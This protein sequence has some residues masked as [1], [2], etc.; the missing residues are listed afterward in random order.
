MAQKTPTHEVVGSNPVV[1]T[2]SVLPKLVDF[3]KVNFFC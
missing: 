2:S 3:L 1:I